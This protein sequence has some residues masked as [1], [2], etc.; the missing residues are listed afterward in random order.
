M[1]PANRANQ[2]HET[3]MRLSC[4][5]GVLLVLTCLANP[6]AAAK[7]FALIVGNSD[8]E[9]APKLTN[10]ANDS[11]LMARTLEG[12]GF[13]VTL[14]QNASYRELKQALLEFGRQLRGEGIEAG[15]F[16]YAGHGVQVKGENYLV[17]INA[18]ITSEDEVG[19]EA[20][21]VNDFL[22]VMNSSDAE[23]NIVVLDACRDNPFKG[24]TRSL[25]RGLAPIDAPKG[26]FIAYATSPGDV[27]LDGTDGNSPYTK[28]LAEAIS[29]PGRPIERVFKDARVSVLAETAE[30]Q[31]PWE[32][33]SITGEFFFRPLASEATQQ[34]EQAQLQVQPQVQPPLQAKLQAEPEARSLPAPQWAQAACIDHRVGN[35]GAKLCVSSIL[36][37]QFGN[38][39]GVGNM[40]D[41]DPATAWVE[42]A[43][44]DGLNEG[45][46][47]TFDGPL[48]LK[49]VRIMNGYNKNQSIF[50]KN[51]RVRVLN[52]D[53]SEGQNFRLELADA[54][55]WQ[56]VELPELK[57]MLWIALSIEDV[58][59][60]SRYSDTAISEL[61]FE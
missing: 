56:S 50:T 51:G 46:V 61:R 14:V 53:T 18:S 23:V 4:I 8:Y 60:G 15:L 26:T 10:P 22:Q 57:P 39:Y 49:R 24:S 38:R 58:Y 5:C 31:V 2:S 45:V 41:A 42:G 36:D 6:A 27:A 30:R 19:L 17:P 34:G 7:R 47:V 54:Q 13:A 40:L 1:T 55:G 25:S 52:M 11:S 35:G 16:Y 21:N 48:A 3:D 20:I 59:R 28:A 33:S 43:D 12:A 9:S 37:P 29:T 44:G 32:V